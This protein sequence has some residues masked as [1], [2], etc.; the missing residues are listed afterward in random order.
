MNHSDARNGATLDSFP[1]NL[2][3]QVSS[4]MILL[5]ALIGEDLRPPFSCCWVL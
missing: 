4:F 1:G 5:E 3:L 2:P